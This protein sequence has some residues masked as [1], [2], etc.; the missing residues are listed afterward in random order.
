[1][2]PGMGDI[3]GITGL[4][5]PAAGLRADYRP[6]LLPPSRSPVAAADLCLAAVR[7][8]ARVSGAAEIPRVLAREPRRAAPLGDGRAFTPAAAGRDSRCRRR[9]PPALT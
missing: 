1:M 6:D 7:R 4:S 8:V 9:V 2:S 5:P 3:D